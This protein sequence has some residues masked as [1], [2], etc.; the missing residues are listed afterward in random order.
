MERRRA[1]ESMKLNEAQNTAVKH[2]DG[3]A[4]VLAGPGSGKTAVITSRTCQLI[5]EAK[6]PAGNILVVTFS[7]KAADNMK[8][9]FFMMQKNYIPSSA[10]A[11]SGGEP[12]P[13]LPYFGTFHSIFFMILRYAYGLTAKN[14]VREEQK[15]DFLREEADRLGLEYEE[16]EEFFSTLLNEIS[17]IKSGSAYIESFR[18]KNLQPEVFRKLY[19]GYSRSL[20]RAGL[21]DFDDM[22]SLALSLLKERP[23]I[24]SCWQGHFRYILIDEFQDINPLQYEIIRLLA[25]PENNLF[26]V[27]DD[28]QSIYGFRG[29]NP[30]IM[31]N[32][33]KD[34]PE[35][36]Q[37]TLNRNYRCRPA[38]LNASLKVIRENRKRFA[39]DLKSAAPGNQKGYGHRRESGIFRIR[40]FPDQ[41]RQYRFLADQIFRHL[42]EGVPPEEI[43]VLVRSSLQLPLLSFFLKELGI[44]VEGYNT[45]TT[46]F[47][48]FIGE[49]IAAY[50][51]LA[52]NVTSPALHLQQFEQDFFRIINR[53]SRYITRHALTE[54]F[55]S[56]RKSPQEVLKFLSVYYRKAPGKQKAVQKLLKDLRMI[57]KCST[58]AA[59]KY[60]RSAMSY[61]DYLLERAEKDRRHPE[62]YRRMLDQ[63]E[64]MLA[65]GAVFPDSHCIPKEKDPTGIQLLTMHSA[66]GLEFS[67]VFLPDLNETILPVKQAERP[68]Q[69]EEE[70]RVFYVAMTRAS[71]NLEISF[72][73]TLHNKKAVPSRFLNCFLSQ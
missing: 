26:V 39:K 45:N 30:E 61:E 2:R 32:F 6:I 62:E 1:F 22:L 73:E 3:P 8:E 57:R 27:G 25:L 50:L 13:A 9:R 54:A 56:G 44:P 71:K 67:F 36:K 15:V 48:S 10:E 52:E 65:E 42:S 4:L 11:S 5:N 31:R 72:C 46:P 41:T 24:L 28:D 68:S 17:C 14:I 63:I 7:R 66:K 69:I 70:R 53:P 16:D 12:L 51:R 35:A 47:Q 43:A 20:S 33:L 37:I 29:A 34:Y 38:I 23:D 49:D 21:I 55:R 60:I 59:V 19:A 58:W 18:P 64:E 40:R